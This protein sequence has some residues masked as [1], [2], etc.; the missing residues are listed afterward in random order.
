MQKILTALL[1]TLV[2]GQ[3]YA[4]DNT[5]TMIKRMIENGI[6]LQNIFELTKGITGYALL[7]GNEGM[8]LYSFDGTDLVFNGDIINKDGVNISSAMK[9][10]YLKIPEPDYLAALEMLKKDTKYFESPLK[11]RNSKK[12]IYVLH[13]PNCGYCRKAWSYLHTN[14]WNEFNVNWVPVA[15]LGEASLKHS[16]LLL[17]NKNPAALMKKLNLGYKPSN[18]EVSKVERLYDQV[19]LN[20]QKTFKA[21]GVQGTPAIIIEIDGKVQVLKGFRQSELEDILAQN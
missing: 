6:E 8:V 12:N 21:F 16:A 10:E 2:V 20:T 18:L 9:K 11:P 14:R 7:N 1:F 17:G 13:D 4:E 19:R 3:S 5:P 15:A